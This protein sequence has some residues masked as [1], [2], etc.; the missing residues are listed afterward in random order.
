MDS[1][2]RYSFHVFSIHFVWAFVKA[3]Q[4][5]ISTFQRSTVDKTATKNLLKVAPLSS[6]TTPD[7]GVPILSSTQSDASVRVGV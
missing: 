1:S 7:V 2:T 4:S 6:C 3:R 5:F